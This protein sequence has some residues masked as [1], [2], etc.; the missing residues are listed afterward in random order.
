MCA[1]YKWELIWSGIKDIVVKSLI[2]VQPHLA[3]NYRTGLPP[4]DDGFSC[5]EVGIPVP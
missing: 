2:S 3:N 5:F 1:G 4:E